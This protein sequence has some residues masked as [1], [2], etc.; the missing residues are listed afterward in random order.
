MASGPEYCEPCLTR[1]QA[2]SRGNVDCPVYD[3]N[4]ILASTDFLGA[5][6]SALPDALDGIDDQCYEAELVVR[7]IAEFEGEIGNGISAFVFNRDFDILERSLW[8]LKRLGNCHALTA[9]EELDHLLR[10]HGFPDSSQSRANYYDK[11]EGSELEE[12]HEAVYSLEERYFTRGSSR[13]LWDDRTAVTK[14]RKCL[15]DSIDLLRNRR[16]HNMTADSTASR[17]ESP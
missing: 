14:A 6:Q 7:G 2:E 16:A 15:E 3:I 4:E 5:I 11:L 17:R 8:S 13:N 12:L 10:N 1:L 9:M